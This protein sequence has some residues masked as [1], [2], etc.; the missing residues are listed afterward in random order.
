MGVYD[1]DVVTAREEI[2]AAGQRVTLRRVTPGAHDPVLDTFGA[3]TT[4]EQTV[5]LLVL[6]AKADGSSLPGAGDETFFYQSKVKTRRRKC[7][8]ALLAGATWEPRPDDELY[9]EGRWWSIPGLSALRPDGGAPIFFDF[10][11]Q[12]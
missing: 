12:A 1:A 7:M 5:A 11:V 10:E 6:P 2:L 3:S 9:F 4:I 8:L